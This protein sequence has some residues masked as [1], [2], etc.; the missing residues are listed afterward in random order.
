VTAT[1][2]AGGEVGGIRRRPRYLAVCLTAMQ[3]ATAYRFTAVFVVMLGF[4]WA[5]ILYFLWEAAFTDT[6]TIGGYTW[7]EMRTYIVVAFGINSLIGWNVAGPMQEAVRS[8][9]IVLEMVRPLNYCGAQ[10]ARYLGYSTVEGA[11]ALGLTV[12]IGVIFL[13]LQPPASPLSGALF[14]VALAGGFLTRALFLFLCSLLT[15]WVLSTAGIMWAQQA[16]TLV[17]SGAIVPVT[18]M[19]WWLQG[20]SNVLPLRGIVATPLAIYL[21]KATGPEM[22]GLVGLQIAWLV[23]LWLVADR[24]WRRAFR[25]VE[26]QGG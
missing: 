14:V 5:F 24:T 8:G 15:F 18:L 2:P 17:L 3:E 25:A 23:V 21:G 26:I 19:P 7:P 11:V 9:D 6:A 12:L 16:V 1:A 4:F 22:L 10:I 20:V 13:G